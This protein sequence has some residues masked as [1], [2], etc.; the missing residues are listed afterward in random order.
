MVFND[1]M[2]QAIAAA[3]KKHGISWHQVTRIEYAMLERYDR[4]RGLCAQSVS[5]GS[6]KSVSAE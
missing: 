1:S 4:L 5:L 6:M 3:A 2:E